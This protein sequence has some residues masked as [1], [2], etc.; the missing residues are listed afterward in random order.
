MNAELRRSLVWP[1]DKELIA[2]LS[3]DDLQSWYSTI[4]PRVMIFLAQDPNFQMFWS[5]V[6]LRKVHR[7][8]FWLKVKSWISW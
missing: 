1:V 7:A 2:A 8:R 6:Y 3:L 5:E 4:N